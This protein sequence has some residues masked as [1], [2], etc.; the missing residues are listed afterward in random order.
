[1]K[2]LIDKN[3]TL[4]AISND[5][6]IQYPR[7]W[8]I[9]KIKA[10]PEVQSEEG[11]LISREDVLHKINHQEVISKSVAR[12]IVEQAQAENDLI[13]RKRV[14]EI[15]NARKKFWHDERAT[16]AL[17]DIIFELTNGGAHGRTDELAD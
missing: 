9:E 7:W 6:G 13:S 4:K 3:E 14:V 5:D 2:N 11:E 16:A 12:R 17:N 1:M 8:Y 15:I 10:I